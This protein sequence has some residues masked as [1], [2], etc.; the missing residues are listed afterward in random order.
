M[1]VSDLGV[2]VAV[3][4]ASGS[5]IVS[6]ILPGIFYYRLYNGDDSQP[7]WKTYA[8][9]GQFLLGLI[10]IPVCLFFIFW[11]ASR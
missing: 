3:V 1:T 11:K 9:L 10:I 4:G 7:A 8:A 5:T 6:Y 2:I